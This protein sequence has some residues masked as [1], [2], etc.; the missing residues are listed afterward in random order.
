M[1]GGDEPDEGH[2]LLRTAEAAEV[3]DLGHQSERAQ[4]VDPT[5]TAKPG[6]QL[7]PRLLLGRLP[8]R[9]PQRLDPAVDEI[10]SVQVGV[11]R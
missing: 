11:E 2:E 6:D 8:D 5:Q 10:D 4:G 9:L 7:P 3:A 1:L